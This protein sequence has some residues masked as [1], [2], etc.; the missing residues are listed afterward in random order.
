MKSEL[1]GVVGRYCADNKS[2]TRETL[3]IFGRTLLREI[4]AVTTAVLRLG[5]CKVLTY[6][7]AAA[8][9]RCSGSPA[10]ARCRILPQQV[11]E[12]SRLRD[13]LHHRHLSQVWM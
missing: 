3:C 11:E 1:A 9:V 13:T 2:G 4:A 5:T 6:G 12:I 7:C 10:P 8:G